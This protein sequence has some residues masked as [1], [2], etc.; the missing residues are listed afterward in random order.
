MIEVM[1]EVNRYFDLNYKP[2]SGVKLKLNEL[3]N[4]FKLK[5]QINSDYNMKLM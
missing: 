1:F 5:G 2:S 4:S 3:C